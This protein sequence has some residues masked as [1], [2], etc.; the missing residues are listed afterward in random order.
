MLAEKFFLLLETLKSHASSDGSPRV[1]STAPHVPIQLPRRTSFRGRLSWRPLSF[2]PRASIP[3]KWFSASRPVSSFRRRAYQRPAP[4]R[5]QLRALPACPAQQRFWMPP[6]C[7][8][9]SAARPCHS[10]PVDHSPWVSIGIPAPAPARL[11]KMPQSKAS[12]KIIFILPLTEKSHSPAIPRSADFAACYH[13][14]RWVV[15]SD[16]DEPHPRA[17]GID[18]F[19][20]VRHRAATGAPARRRRACWAASR[21]GAS[22]SSENQASPVAASSRGA[23]PALCQT[24]MPDDDDS[25]PEDRN[26][27]PLRRADRI[28]ADACRDKSCPPA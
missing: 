14:V 6:A 9:L 22:V 16:L 21:S 1:V 27:A 28:E 17:P 4:G 19:E 8:P 7:P 26:A 11:H 5:P 20:A 10:R 23:A 24:L 2:Q 12:S 18:R 3:G 15:A 25:R 13:E